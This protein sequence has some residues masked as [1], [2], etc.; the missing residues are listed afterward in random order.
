MPLAEATAAAIAEEEPRTRGGERVEEE[1]V[2]A[3]DA[4][5]CF[6]WMGR[7]MDRWSQGSR[8]EERVERASIQ[9]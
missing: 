5:A 1:T 8:G 2:A 3:A 4:R 6:D 7:D 9:S